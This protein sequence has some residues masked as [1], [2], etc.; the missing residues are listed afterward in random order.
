MNRTIDI[1]YDL[2][3]VTCNLKLEVFLCQWRINKATSFVFGDRFTAN[4]TFLGPKEKYIMRTG[5]ACTLFVTLFA[6]AAANASTILGATDI[7]NNTLGDRDVTVDIGNIIDQSGLSSG[8]TSGVT[9]FDTYIGGN[10]S[11]TLVAVNNEWFANSGVTSGLVDFD[12]GGAYSLDRIAI[13]NEN[14]AGISRLN[15][16]TSLDSLFAASTLVGTFSLTNNPRNSDYIADVLTLAAITDARYVRF[17]ILGAY[18]DELG[19][20]NQASLG[21][22]AF[23]VSPVPVPAAAWL[24]GTALIG[25]VGMSRRTKVA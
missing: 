24:F 16:F 25:F 8:Y 9:D 10:P 3:G 11:H 7:I 1:A 23:S 5:I 21:E 6:S 2:L 22:V 15:I 4:F 14:A 12:L 13:W 19:I 20:A 17:D 18:P